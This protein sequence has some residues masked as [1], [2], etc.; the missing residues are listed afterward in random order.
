MEPRIV[1]NFTEGKEMMKKKREELRKEL[2]QAEKKGVVK[3]KSLKRLIAIYSVSATLPAEIDG[4]IVN[5][6]ALTRFIK[7]LK[8]FRYEI[9]VEG[10]CLTVNYGK[11]RREWTGKLVLYD[12]S[13]Y[14]EGYPDIPKLVMD[15]V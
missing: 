6:L 5:G 2:N 12:M 4:I 1:G 9:I 11:T 7:K 3:A 15:R 10:D 14:F 13:S 8:G